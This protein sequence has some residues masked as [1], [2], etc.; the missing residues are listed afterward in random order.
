[1]IRETGTARET[2]EVEGRQYCDFVRTTGRLWI[3]C[4]EKL[5]SLNRWTDSNRRTKRIDATGEVLQS[6][7]TSFAL[8][9]STRSSLARDP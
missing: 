2:D 8:V 4:R 6:Y 5:M 3:D 1:M 7:L 9:S